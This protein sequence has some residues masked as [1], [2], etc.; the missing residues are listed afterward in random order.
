[1]AVDVA[2]EKRRLGSS[3][4]RTTKLAFDDLLGELADRFVQVVVRGRTLQ[5]DAEPG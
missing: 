1:M 3:R 4:S 5:H 2:S